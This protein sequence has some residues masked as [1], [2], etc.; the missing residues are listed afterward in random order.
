M[1]LSAIATQ[2]GDEADLRGSASAAAA[3]FRELGADFPLLAVMHDDGLQAIDAG[4]YP[5][6]RASL[7]EALERARELSARDE[8]CNN[9]S[10]LGV[11]A[12]YERR[13]DDALRLFAESLHLARQG[14]WHQV[15]LDFGA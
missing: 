13:F 2:E 10:D 5:R 15:A 3:I 14:S 9:L 1:I 12:L 4:D 6:A 11:L 8:I 7:E